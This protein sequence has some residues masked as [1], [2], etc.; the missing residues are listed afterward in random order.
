MVKLNEIYPDGK[1]YKA[2]DIKS[3]FTARI[4][5]VKTQS[6]KDNTKIV[7]TL[8]RHENRL[9]CNKT[10]GKRIAKLYGE[11]TDAWIGKEIKV[12]VE[13]VLF[14]GKLTPGIHIEP[15]GVQAKVA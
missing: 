5:D 15:V 9:T 8:D 7:L 6:M 3:S 12:S 1:L 13:D 14:Q 11:D 2:S 10:N 4:V